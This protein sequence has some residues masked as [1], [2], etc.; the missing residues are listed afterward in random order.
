MPTFTDLHA[1]HVGKLSAST[2][3]GV[4][5]FKE[6]VGILGLAEQKHLGKG[7]LFWAMNQATFTKLKQEGLSINAAGAI[8]TGAEPVMPVIGGAV[9]I[10]DF[11][12]AN[13]IVGG[14]GQEYKLVQRKGIK[15]ALS[16]HAQFIEDNTLFKGTSR[17]DGMPYYG[18]GFAAFS[19]TT[20]AVTKSVTFAEDTANAP[21]QQ[22]GGT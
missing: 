12:P 8:V 20:T 19:L 10:L 15:I 21:A 1:S 4:D 14:Y 5:L 16:E 17:W 3:K 7:D 18:E 2:V 22:G 11:G 13:N 6:L 9:E